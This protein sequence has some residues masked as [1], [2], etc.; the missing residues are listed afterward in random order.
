MPG[1]K[2]GTD[3][4]GALKIVYVRLQQKLRLF[5]STRVSLLCSP[6]RSYKRLGLMFKLQQTSCV[7]VA[8]LCRS[9]GTALLYQR[10]C[11]CVVLLCR[12]RRWLTCFL[13][14]AVGLLYLLCRYRV[15]K[16][17]CSLQD[18]CIN[19]QQAMLTL[20]SR[21]RRMKN[22]QDFGESLDKATKNRPTA[23]YNRWFCVFDLGSKG[24]MHLH[25]FTRIPMAHVFGLARIRLG[26]HG[27]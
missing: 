21:W 24:R 11:F 14:V 25:L 13:N 26:S 19:T 23:V 8:G 2:R 6:N 9:S 12:I 22:D 4:Y 16:C 20:E 7:S 3:L 18:H 15:H 10:I 1:I 5:R 27:L 17:V